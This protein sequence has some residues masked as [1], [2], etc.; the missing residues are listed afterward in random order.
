[1]ADDLPTATHPSTLKRFDTSR[2]DPS[3]MDSARAV[4]LMLTGVC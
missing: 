3:A 4:E 1:M 2:A